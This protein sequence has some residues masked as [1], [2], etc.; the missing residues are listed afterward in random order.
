[1][2]PIRLRTPPKI[3]DDGEDG[4][5][6]F[7]AFSSWVSILFSIRLVAMFFGF[8]PWRSGS[9]PQFQLH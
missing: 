7:D 3:R 2:L 1:M 9:W 8:R 4:S 6:G 5:F